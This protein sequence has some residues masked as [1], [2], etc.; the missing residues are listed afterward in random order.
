MRQGSGR[1]E[2]DCTREPERDPQTAVLK[3]H[4][5]G[6]RTCR[7]VDDLG[8]SSIG[9]YDNEGVPRAP[10]DIEIPLRVEAHSVGVHTRWQLAVDPRATRSPSSDRNGD[11]SM[12]NR[13]CYDDL[14]V[15]GRNRQA[16]REAGQLGEDLCR[17]AHVRPAEASASIQALIGRLRL[18]YLPVMRIGEVERPVRA[19][20]DVIRAVRETS[21]ENAGIDWFDDSVQCQALDATVDLG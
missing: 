17:P 13:L 19:E 18:Q 14:R 9:I 10:R 3:T 8:D 20:A 12:L 16:I 7:S 2:A 21:G 11:E 1:D 4:V 6:A 5:G 15:V